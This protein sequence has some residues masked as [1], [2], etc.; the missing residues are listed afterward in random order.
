MGP[1][2]KLCL[3]QIYQHPISTTKESQKMMQTGMSFHFSLGRGEED[4]FKLYKF[5]SIL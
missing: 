2:G 5:T 3:E 1:R 4:L